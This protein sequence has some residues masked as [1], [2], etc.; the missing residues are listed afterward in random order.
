LGPVLRLVLLSLLAC[1]VWVAVRALP[2]LLW[3]VSGW[4]LFA[5]WKA[6]RVPGADHSE[7]RVPVAD[8]EALVDL[9]A[10]LIGDRPGV[11]LATGL[12]RLEGRGQ[13]EGLEL[14]DVRARLE[15]LGV[16]VRRSVKVARRVAYGVHR[17]DLPGR[18]PVGADEP[19]A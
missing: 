9:L 16:P 13:G 1:A 3:L 14:A 19:A 4:W 7:G 10:G 2:W 6:G 12:A 5:A 17:E 8:R 18:S 15:A 11:H